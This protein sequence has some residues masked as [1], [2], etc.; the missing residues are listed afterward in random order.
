[1]NGITISLPVRGPNV[2]PSN[3]VVAWSL[4]LPFSIDLLQRLFGVL[5]FFRGYKP[6]SNGIQELF[7]LQSEIV[8]IA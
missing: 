7:L 8:L 3:R 2:L 5:I 6:L 4:L 1:M